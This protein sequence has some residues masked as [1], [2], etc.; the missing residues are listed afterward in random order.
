[1]ILENWTS[2]DVW[3][4][5]TRPAELFMD[6]IAVTVDQPVSQNNHGLQS[7]S[8]RVFPS[9]YC[10]WLKDFNFSSPIDGDQSVAVVE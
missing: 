1:M 10:A 3:A 5:C 6:F 8:F 4:W 2:V 7:F 9:S